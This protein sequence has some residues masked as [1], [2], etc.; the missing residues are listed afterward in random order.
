MPINLYFPIAI[1]C[2]E[3]KKEQKI[4]KQEKQKE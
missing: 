4:R 1:N 3:D 2:E